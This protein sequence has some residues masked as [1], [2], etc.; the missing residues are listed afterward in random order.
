MKI[1]RLLGIV[2]ILL[3]REKVTAPYLAEHFEVSRRTI[4]R[5]IE[6]LCM[7]G[8]PIVTT[9]GGNGGITIAEGYRIDRS[10]LTRDELQTLIV[11]LKGLDSVS[12]D[13]HTE[14][15]MNKFFVRQDNVVSLRD[16]III[17]LASHHKNQLTEK[18]ALLREAIRNNRI[19]RFRYY[20]S[21]GDELRRAEPYYL[22]FRWSAWYLYG[23]CRDRKDYRLFK[24]NRMWELVVTE[25]LFKPGDIPEDRKN[26]DQYFTDDLHFTVLFDREVRYRLIEEYGPGCY[27]ETEEGRLLFSGSF[28]NRDFLIGWL[29]GFGNKAKVIEPRELCQ[30][31]KM[32]AEGILKNYSDEEA[33]I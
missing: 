28:T 23:Y 24:M 19:V 12:K 1:D 4:N 20:S 16:S 14:Q 21:K 13:K 2:M 26:L 32:I 7:A 5:D 27:S 31:L 6:D 29:L 3:Q 22:T 18:I 25:E 8:I 17:D 10:V 30:E 15:L 11:G 9:Q 33:G